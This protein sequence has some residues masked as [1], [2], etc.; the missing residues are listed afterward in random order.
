VKDASSVSLVCAGFFITLLTNST[1]L[2]RRIS[3]KGARM[4]SKQT[5]TAAE[6]ATNGTA[7]AET[8]TDGVAS[9]AMATIAP[10]ETDNEA[11]YLAAVNDTDTIDF[12]AAV[13]E[14]KQILEQIE[15]AE[16]GQL[17]LGELAAKL[18]PKYGDRT[19]A[20]FADELGIATCTLHRYRAV[21]QA[22][23]G[24][25]APGPLSP[26]YAVL[27]EL[28]AL[29][30][31]E[32]I[33]REKPNM[34]KR[35]AAEIKRKRKDAKPPEQD[36]DVWLKKFNEGFKGACNRQAEAARWA[37]GALR[38]T[39]TELDR[40]SQKIESVL[41]SN[42]R[43]DAKLVIQAC[44][45]LEPFVLDEEAAEPEQEAQEET[46]EHAHREVPSQDGAE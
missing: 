36:K 4:G 42:A 25:V 41:L 44:E 29:D 16:R 45:L 27:R 38:L 10:A 39:N 6:T 21:Y 9:V 32:E 30:D 7:S 40:A 34:T 15:I 17:R 28:Q 46:T 3:G 8:A 1:L 5:A 26:S 19:L 31:R 43:R 24:K 20:N 12:N 22:W 35:E 2:E 14:G 11:E 18:E 13:V 37:E 33:I 23:K